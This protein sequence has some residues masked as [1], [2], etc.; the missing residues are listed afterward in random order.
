MSIDAELVSVLKAWKQSTQFSAEED[1][2]F[3]SP[4]KIGR[5]P[6]VHGCAARI[7]EGRKEGGHWNS[8]NAQHEAH[9]QDMAGLCWYV[10]GGA[11][12]VNAPCG[13]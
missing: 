12:K 7:P 8:G 2:I 11:A 1:W 3:A 4:V 6:F 5:L 13:R 10:R 9:V